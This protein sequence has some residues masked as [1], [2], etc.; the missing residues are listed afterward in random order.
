MQVI[1]ASLDRARRG[2][3]R[4]MLEFGDLTISPSRNRGL[5]SAAIAIYRP[6]N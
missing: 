2:S 5:F 3:R 1:S 6:V 4:A